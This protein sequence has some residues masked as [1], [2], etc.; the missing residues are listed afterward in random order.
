MFH[1]HFHDT[2]RVHFIVE[3]PLL[4]KPL[5]CPLLTNKPKGSL[6]YILVFHGTTYFYLS[7]LNGIVVPKMSFYVL[8]ILWSLSSHSMIHKE[9]IFC[10]YVALIWW[11]R[12]RTA[13]NPSYSIYL[14]HVTLIISQPQSEFN[15]TAVV[16][17]GKN[18]GDCSNIMLMKTRLVSIEWW[19][20]W[21]NW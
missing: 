17:Y 18:S 9:P 7:S 11:Y 15:K 5:A 10:E 3:H 8:K 6:S 2:H 1:F 13:W 16:L 12:K 21:R 19:L 14:A 4:N 20:L